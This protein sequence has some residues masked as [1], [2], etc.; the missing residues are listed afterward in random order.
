MYLLDNS[1]KTLLVD[2]TTTFRDVVVTLLEK[3]DVKEEEFIAD[4]FAIYTSSDGDSIDV[5]NH[6][7]DYVANVTSK[8]T[9]TARLVMMIRLFVP[10]IRGIMTKEDLA[11]DMGKNISIVPDKY[12]YEAAPVLDE[13]LLHLQ[14]IQAVY[15]IITGT[16]PTDY[17]TALTLGAYY[18]IHKFGQVGQATMKPGLI[19][20]GIGEYI[21]LKHLRGIALDVAE[22]DLLDRIQSLLSTPESKVIRE[23]MTIV[24]TQESIAEHTFFRGIIWDVATLPTKAVMGVNHKNIVILNKERQVQQTYNIEY[25]LRWGYNPKKDFFFDVQDGQSEQPLHVRLESA[26]G[27]EIAELLADYALAFLK[28]SQ[29]A[30]DLAERHQAEP[31]S[32]EQEEIERQA[33]NKRLSNASDS[34]VGSLFNTRRSIAATKVVNFDQPPPLPPAS[35]NEHK[36]AMKLQALHRGNSAREKVGQMVQD[37]IDNGEID[38]DDMSV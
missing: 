16:Y 21:P 17:H 26:A 5:A 35:E 23:Y 15:F 37:M 14:F 29:H 7:D 6:K 38:I 25:V 34:A 8:L 13:N 2:D 22:Q 10:S 3:M 4:F 32:P 31:P 1:S 18:F 28:A 20:R 19:G 30:K 36:A 33:R 12:Y 9:E 24:W 27:H 11:A